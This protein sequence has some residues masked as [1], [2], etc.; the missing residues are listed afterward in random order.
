MR[1]STAGWQICAQWKN[2]FTSCK[3]LKYLKESHPV[4]I[5]EY[6]VAQGIDHEPVFNWWVDDVMRKR[7]RII[8]LVKKR[9]D[10]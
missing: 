10:Q 3:S 5:D 9:N 8:A 7:E 6:A 2:G 1:K 4:Q